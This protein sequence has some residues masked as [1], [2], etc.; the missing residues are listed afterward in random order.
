VRHFQGHEPVALLFV[1]SFENRAHA[2][3]AEDL[4]DQKTAI[5]HMAPLEWDALCFDRVVMLRHFPATDH[6]LQRAYIVAFHASKLA[7]IDL[8]W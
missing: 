4:R 1:F 3:A 8:G 5:Q 7:Q 2:A 6:L